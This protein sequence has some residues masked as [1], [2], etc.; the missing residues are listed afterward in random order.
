MKTQ[1]KSKG[2]A[3]FAIAAIV[4]LVVGFAMGVSDNGKLLTASV[5]SGTS[6]S[7]IQTKLNQVSDT[8]AKNE[9]LL[10]DL[11]NRDSENQD[12][13]AQISEL[14]QGNKELTET[15]F[16]LLSSLNVEQPVII[17]ST[18]TSSGHS[19]KETCTMKASDC[20]GYETFSKSSCACISIPPARPDPAKNIL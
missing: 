14:K 11:E 8:M 6:I 20:A 18:S 2:L 1:K 4:L 10:N 15:A 13:E 7:D 12:L 9:Q 5:I 19:S 17:E 3:V 16:E